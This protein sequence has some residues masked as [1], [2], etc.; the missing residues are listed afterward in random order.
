MGPK[1]PISEPPPPLFLRRAVT[2]MVGLGVPP[3]RATEGWGQSEDLSPSL[4]VRHPTT[5]VQENGTMGDDGK[6]AGCVS[7]AALLSLKTGISGLPGPSGRP[8]SR[9]L[10]NRSCR[11]GCA[12]DRRQCNAL[13]GRRIGVRPCGHCGR[14]SSLS[15]S[16]SS[17]SVANRN[18]YNNRYCD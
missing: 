4:S 18:G 2:P 16:N 12:S 17:A 11:A 8:S 14:P 15:S 3:P 7:L 10:P 5:A 9:R 13:P 6:A 1:I